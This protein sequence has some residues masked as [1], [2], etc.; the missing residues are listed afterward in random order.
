MD[1]PSDPRLY[2]VGTEFASKWIKMFSAG[3]EKGCFSGLTHAME[4]GKFKFYSPLV[5]KPY[6][7]KIGYVP[8]LMSVTKVLKGL[9]YVGAFVGT[10]KAANKAKVVLHFNAMVTKDGK[11]LKADGV[12]IFEV[13]GNTGKATQLMVMVRPFGVTIG[14]RDGMGAMIEAFKNGKAP[15]L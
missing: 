14:L 10:D 5:N 3:D 1:L 2:Q 15:K 13:D 6:S 12:D 7:K 9:H 8:I 4:E 11:E